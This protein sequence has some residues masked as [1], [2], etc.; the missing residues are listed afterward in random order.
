MD[1]DQAYRAMDLLVEADTQAKVQEAV[2]FACADLL[3]PRGRP[4]VLRHHQH[5]LRARRARRSR[6]DGAGV[7]RLRA[8]QGSPPRP[9]AGRDRPRRHARGDP[10]PRV[11]AGPATPTTCRSSKRS[12]TTCAAGGSGRVVTV[13]DRGFSSDENLRYLTRAGGHWIAGERMRDGSPDAAGRAVA[14]GPLPDRPRQ[15]ARQGGP[16]RR[17]RRRQALHRLPQPRRG[18][19]RQAAQRDDTI[20]PPAGRA[21]RGSRP[22]RA[23]A[24]NAKASRGASPRR[25]RA[26]RPP[27][28][29]ALPAPDQDRPAADRPRQDQGRGAPGRQVPALHLRPRPVAPRT[30]RSA[31]RTCS[32]PNAASAT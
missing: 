5:V 10:G 13:V 16:R 19:P 15:P 30:S 29:R 1:E 21:R 31:T 4:A 3:E 9:A 18:R 26:A 7:P 28:A 20:A 32:K 17:R 25:V 27:H 6:R 11:G 2:F 23:K 8:L 22:Q 12:R 24:K 14:P